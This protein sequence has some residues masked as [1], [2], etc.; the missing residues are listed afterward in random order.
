MNVFR[1]VVPDDLTGRSLMSRSWGRGYS[2]SWTFAT[3]QDFKYY[4]F[5]AENETE[6]HHRDH[7][8]KLESWRIASS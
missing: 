1:K 7:F 8:S 6:Y 2:F 5:R 3:R 4:N